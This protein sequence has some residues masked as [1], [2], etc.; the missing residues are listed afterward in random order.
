[1]LI[2]TIVARMAEW[3]KAPDSSDY[4]LRTRTS[5]TWAFWYRDRCVG[6]NPT[7]CTIFGKNYY[8]LPVET[9]LYSSHSL[10]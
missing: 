8:R 5:V 7:P 9:P 3:S 4:M 6:S 2:A 1:M 10:E